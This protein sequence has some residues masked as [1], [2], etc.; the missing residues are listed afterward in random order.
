LGECIGVSEQS[1]HSILKKLYDKGYI[2]KQE[3]TKHVRASSKWYDTVVLMKSKINT[4]ESLATLKKVEPD[5][6]ESLAQD[7]KESLVNNNI[8][9]NNKIINTL[10][11][12]EEIPEEDIKE[13]VSEYNITPKQLKEKAESLSD[14]CRYKGRKYRNYKA[15]LRNAIRKEFSKRVV[16]PTLRYDQISDDMRKSNIERMKNIR[17]KVGI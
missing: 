11:Y 1:V 9:D 12:L 3:E 17:K 6:K 2:E 8:R 15:F 4:K 5:T 7:T 10:S 14:Y 13:F 16:G